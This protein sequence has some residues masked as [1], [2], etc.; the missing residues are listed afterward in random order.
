MTQAGGTGVSLHSTTQKGGK[1]YAL[2][3]LNWSGQLFFQALGR[4]HRAGGQDSEQF[5]VFANNSVEQRVYDLLSS[6]IQFMEDCVG[7]DKEFRIFKSN[8]EEEEEEK[9][10][11]MEFE[12]EEDFNEEKIKMSLQE[13]LHAVDN[14]ELNEDTL[15]N[16]K[17][18]LQKVKIVEK[19]SGKIQAEFVKS[20]NREEEITY[21][22]HVAEERG[23]EEKIEF[24]VSEPE[25]KLKKA[26]KSIKAKSDHFESI[27]QFE[28][29]LKD[30]GYCVES[31]DDNKWIIY[32][33]TFSEYSK[34]GYNNTR[35]RVNGEEL[36]VRIRRYK[37]DGQILP[38]NNPLKWRESSANC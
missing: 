9:D 24:K 36:L 8:D 25:A 37:E 12:D 4:V 33:E 35:I 31:I 16:V 23:F 29:L 27:P 30:N 15:Y 19:Q 22:N 5:L 2:H 11:D 17:D 28:D 3:C 7:L 34:A 18:L 26:N 20:E 32:E 1:R 13:I 10:F 38:T 14:M 6:K 21:L